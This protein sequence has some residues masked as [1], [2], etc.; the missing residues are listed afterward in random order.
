M[1]IT[2]YQADHGYIA[3]TD[4]SPPKFKDV[5][6]IG[7]GSKSGGSLTDITEQAYCVS[8]LAKMEILARKDVPAD[9]VTALGYDQPVVVVEEFPVVD[10]CGN[11]LDLMPIERY[12]YPTEVG[13]PEYVFWL[14]VASIAVGFAIGVLLVAV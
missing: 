12:E 9:W 4:Q 3:V 5:L 10:E 7:K 8:Q 14:W 1:K 2:Y 6:Y 13:T 11:L